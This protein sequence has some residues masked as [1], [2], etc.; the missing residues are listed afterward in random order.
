[1]TQQPERAR[2]PSGVTPQK[3]AEGQVSVWTFPRPP[4]VVR[5]SR[6]VVVTLGG[7]VVCQ[8]NRALKVLETSHPPT[9]YL[10]MADFARG[11]LRVASGSSFCEYKGVANY[12]D[13][14]ANPSGEV[15]IDR[16]AGGRAVV[17]S[18][19]AWGYP[20]PS[21]RFVELRDHVAVYAAQLDSVTVADEQVVPQAGGFYG[22]WIT[23]DVVGPFKGGEG[24]RGW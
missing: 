6:T 17:A 13:I 15:A 4:V 2:I 16:V 18:R 11:S 19:A 10:P 1:M 12:Y 7:Q 9:W 8:T 20:K 3:P 21:A 23:S 14:V 5:D 24:T 22:G